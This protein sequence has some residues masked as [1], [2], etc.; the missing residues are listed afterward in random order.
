MR[1]QARYA[2]LIFAAACGPTADAVQVW[3]DPDIG[4]P[5]PV[6]YADL[7]EHDMGTLWL[8][9]WIDDVPYVCERLDNGIA[10]LAEVGWDDE[11]IGYRRGGE[12]R[13][14][15]KCDN[16]WQVTSPFLGEVTPGYDLPRL[17]IEQGTVYP[18]AQEI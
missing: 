10:V 11:M 15:R 17:R 1:Q 2:L 3:W 13:K 8:V 6:E 9:T 7:V 16:K 12:A 5:V 14:V 4:P 18:E